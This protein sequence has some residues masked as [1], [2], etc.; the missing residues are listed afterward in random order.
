MDD[1]I[2]RINAEIEQTYSF[3][4]SMKK[5]Q[6]N[7]LI[8]IVSLFAAVIYSMLNN[9]YIYWILLSSIL[10]IG[11]V[12]YF[13]LNSIF[14]QRENRVA[15]ENIQLP[16]QEK[17]GVYFLMRADCVLINIDFFC[18]AIALFFVTNFL[19]LIA[20]FS[21]II[22]GDLSYFQNNFLMFSIT[23]WVFIQ[24]ICAMII[25]WFFTSQKKLIQTAMTFG[26]NVIGLSKL[27]PLKENTNRRTFLG[28]FFIL[29]FI[30]FCLSL[31]ISVIAIIQMPNFNIFT[32]VIV[33]I[34]QV[35]ILS[36]FMDYFSS[37][38]VF[39]LYSTKIYQLN[40]FRTIFEN[41][42]EKNFEKT[43]DFQKL[44]KS[45][46]LTKLYIPIRIEWLV[47]F[48]CYLLIPNIA[49]ITEDKHEI[50]KSYLGVK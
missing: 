38:I 23:N 9:L 48:S 34:T 19:I 46:E 45:F 37:Q 30:I 35:V 17:V 2:T 8:S 5:D 26:L 11:I 49:I 3:I 33:L 50:M 40:L 22:K 27:A 6:M 42:I 44:E 28:V 21:G 41:M 24:V 7:F 14:S 39:N 12:I 25:A 36:L 32:S 20:F 16:L 13:I 47:F 10:F 18:K 1:I 15:L 43:D 4:S 29:T 31:I